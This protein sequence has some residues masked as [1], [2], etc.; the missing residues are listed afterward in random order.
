MSRVLQGKG[1]LG[2]E[3]IN[4]L[5]EF[6]IHTLTFN[7]N[8]TVSAPWGF[9]QKLVSGSTLHQCSSAS[10]GCQSSIKL[11]HIYFLS[12]SYCMQLMLYLILWMCSVLSSLRSSEPFDDQVLMAWDSQANCLWTPDWLTQSLVLR[13]TPFLSGVLS[14]FVVSYGW[15]MRCLN[16][17]YLQINAFGN[18]LCKSHYQAFI[19]SI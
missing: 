7:H 14:F 8:I 13:N 16:Y 6:T 17:F 2:G 18:T 9:Y 15:F 19:S 5:P 12:A 1:I 4:C 11:I 10:G 3:S